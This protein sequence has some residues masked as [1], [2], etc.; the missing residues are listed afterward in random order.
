MKNLNYIYLPVIINYRPNHS[1]DSSTKHNIATEQIAVNLD[2]VKSIEP[3]T[4]SDDT[5]ITVIYMA[6]GDYD[7]FRTPVTVPDLLT[8][9]EYAFNP[10]PSLKYVPDIGEVTHQS[11]L[12]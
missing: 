4:L 7:I 2:W 9:M 6:A 12:C 5:P 10:I 8:A 3:G 11:H 1:T